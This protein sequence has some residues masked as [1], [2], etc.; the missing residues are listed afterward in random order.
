MNVFKIKALDNDFRIMK[1]NAIEI[2][3]FQTQI[4]FDSIDASQKFFENILERI[5]VRSDSAWLP[6]KEKKRNIYYPAGIETN[7]DA[8]NEL[9]TYFTNDYLKPLFQKSNESSK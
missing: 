5:E 9:L 4:S 7:I 2:L 8:I 3:A 1:M 6:I